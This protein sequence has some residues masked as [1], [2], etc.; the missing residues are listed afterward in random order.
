MDT[1]EMS[2]IVADNRSAKQFRIRSKKFSR[3]KFHHVCVFINHAKIKN[4]PKMEATEN[5]LRRVQIE[6][7]VAKADL[8]HFFCG[9]PFWS[10]FNILSRIRRRKSHPT[11]VEYHSSVRC[12]RSSDSD[13]RSLPRQ[14]ALVRIN[15]RLHLTIQQRIDSTSSC[16]NS[17]GVGR[18]AFFFCQTKH[19]IIALSLKWR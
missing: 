6:Y 17:L 12:H 1:A 15:F 16:I 13:D 9:F 19:D 4:F 3:Q 5:F 11:V 8:W 7:K 18:V 14:A 10:S 2:P